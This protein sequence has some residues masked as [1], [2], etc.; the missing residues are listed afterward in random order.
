MHVN[1]QKKIV[2]PRCINN[3]FRIESLTSELESNRIESWGAK[4]FPPL[5]LTELHFLPLL[6]RWSVVVHRTVLDLHSQTKLQHSAEQLK[7]LRPDLKHQI[8]PYSASDH[9]LQER[10]H[11]NLIWGS[12]FYTLRKD[13]SN[14]SFLGEQRI[15]NVVT[16]LETLPSVSPDVKSRSFFKEM[17]GHFQQIL[18]WIKLASSHGKSGRLH[19][20]LWRPKHVL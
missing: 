6:A 18:W 12:I 10:T 3:W 9:S 19:L 20:W 16:P 11:H 1:V 14:F 8:S 5:K 15:I 2:E 4:R 7:Q 17:F 13:H